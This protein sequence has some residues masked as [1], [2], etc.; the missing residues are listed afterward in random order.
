M[1]PEDRSIQ[2]FVNRELDYQSIRVDSLEH[3]LRSVIRQNQQ[4]QCVQLAVV[5]P[6]VFPIV[7][8]P[9]R[10]S[11]PHQSRRR[12]S[13]TRKIHAH[14]LSMFAL[15]TQAGDG[16]LVM[17]MSQEIKG[18]DGGQGEYP[19]FSV[20]GSNPNSSTFHLNA[21]EKYIIHG[22]V[23]DREE[24]IYAVSRKALFELF[25]MRYCIEHILAYA[26]V[27][28]RVGSRSTSFYSMSYPWP[29]ETSFPSWDYSLIDRKDRKLTT[30]FP[31]PELPQFKARIRAQKDLI[32]GKRA[33][34]KIVSGLA[35]IMIKL[36][37]NRRTV[38]QQQV[39]GC[40]I[41]LYVMQKSCTIS[42]ARVC[43]VSRMDYFTPTACCFKMRN[44]FHL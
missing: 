43:S 13:T 28:V 34:E 40:A 15:Y 27:T 38:R 24:S 6:F 35:I 3:L 30:Y 26:P 39:T 25:G 29:F 14:P 22:D 5:I 4:V 19:G 20:V 1:R 2:R 18:H 37:S 31:R 8:S 42:I 36:S 41:D 33:N 11:S 10:P 23:S 17:G 44:G 16:V 21:G 7:P 12:Y 9:P 32:L